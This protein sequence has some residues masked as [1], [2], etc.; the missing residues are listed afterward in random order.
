M[1]TLRIESK[2]QAYADVIPGQLSEPL[3][4]YVDWTRFMSGAPVRELIS[5]R[6]VV[7]P[8]QTL[9]LSSIST[10]S[11]I[12][13]GALYSLQPH[14][15]ILNRYQVRY[16]SGAVSNPLLPLGTGLLTIG[17]TYVVT[18]NTDG[19]INLSDT[20]V[21]PVNFNSTV[22]RNE[23]VYIAGSNFGDTGPFNSLNQG[24]WT[25]V[26]IKSIGANPGAE[27]VLKR[28][29]AT[30]PVGTPETQIATAATNIQL[31]T[32]VTAAL[33]VG[34]PSYAGVW[35]ITESAQGW[36]SVD[37]LNVLPQLTNVALQ[38]LTIAEDQFLGYFRVEVDGPAILSCKSGDLTQGSQL[39][40]PVVFSDPLAVP[41]GGWSE[42]YGFYSALTVQN[43]GDTALNV[44]VILA[45]LV[46]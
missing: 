32:P 21:T 28:V 14:P 18:Q 3:Q 27:M 33:I 8:G 26:T 40:R 1:P 9:T 6:R 36:F 31:V 44:N 34:A 10:I 15:T 38:A 5:D 39:L 43:V 41:V 16:L 13:A 20:S 29:D 12:S 22:S 17:N 35:T 11:G 45:N 30:Q 7:D 25:V 2:I 4:R 37:S 46:N 19:S 42:A 24:F 23:T